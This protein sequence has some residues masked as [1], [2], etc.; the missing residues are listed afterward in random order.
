M[1][2]VNTE[3]F[4]PIGETSYTPIKVA[5]TRLLFIDDELRTQQTM[6]DVLSDEAEVISAYTGRQGLERAREVEPDV[7]L[8]DIGL[9]DLDGIEV[10][11]SLNSHPGSPPV[12]MLTAHGEASLVV[13]AIK[14]GAYDYIV[15]PYDLQHLRGAIRQALS[16]HTHRAGQISVDQQSHG[17]IG[18]SPGMRRVRDIIE[19]FAPSASPVLVLGESGTGKELVARAIHS[20]S[21]R[22][23]PFVP[24]NCGAIPSSLVEAELFGSVRGAFTDAVDRPGAFEKAD[25]GSLFLD[26][27]GDMP[28][29]SQVKLLRVLEER[30][31]T[32]IGASHSRPLDVR[33][34]A[35]TNRDLKDGA[36]FRKDLY[37]RLSVLPI[38]I[39][40]LRE[41]TEDIPVLAAHFLRKLGENRLSPAAREALCQHAWTGNVRELRNVLERAVL[42]AGQ[43]TIERKDIVF[44]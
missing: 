19:R 9:P 8:L 30:E 20:C 44:D 24:I 16:A 17:I 15:K 43:G 37:Y 42:L 14:G 29:A 5:M 13:E 6:K 36:V 4:E 1:W 31:V 41:R 18:E 38:I 35:A 28:M 23:G 22:S 27:I 7:I 2:R 10:L 12:I 39:S 3:A 33:V 40:P 21:G 34:I 25:K 32:R 26:E 11:R